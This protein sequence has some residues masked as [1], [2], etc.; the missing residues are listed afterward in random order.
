MRRLRCGDVSQARLK[1][2]RL[3]RQIGPDGI[4]GL[5]IGRERPSRPLDLD[6]GFAEL[7][8]LRGGAWAENATAQ[9]LAL[10]P[11][12]LPR[13]RDGQPLQPVAPSL[14]GFAAPQATPVEPLIEFAQKAREL[15]DRARQESAL[16]ERARLEAGLPRRAQ[17]ER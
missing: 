11:T 8:P 10:R 3:V 17:V 15:R 7:Q 13:V 9:L 1:Q 14:P 16:R 12:P 5:A 6:T 4:R 2:L